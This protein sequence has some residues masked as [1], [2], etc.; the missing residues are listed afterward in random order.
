MIADD[1]VLGYCDFAHH[2]IVPMPH[3]YFDQSLR[4]RLLGMFIERLRH[5]YTLAKRMAKTQLPVEVAQEAA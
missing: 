2:R 4:P 5:V 1:G 3:S